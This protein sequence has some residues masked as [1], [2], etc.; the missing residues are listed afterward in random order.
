[1]PHAFTN[2][3]RPIWP[4]FFLWWFPNRSI[5]SRPSGVCER[6]S[7]WKCWIMR[8][9]SNCF[10][11]PPWTDRYKQNVF[12]LMAVVCN[13]V[14]IYI[15]YIIWFEASHQWVIDGD[16]KISKP[17]KSTYFWGWTSRNLIEAFGVNRRDVLR[18][19]LSLPARSSTRLASIV[20]V[21]NFEMGLSENDRKTMEHPH[22][23]LVHH[24][25]PHQSD[26]IVTLCRDCS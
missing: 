25:F 26:S 14:G 10:R 18:R 5:L 1:M 21:G 9:W 23:L 4:C 12:Q 11:R 6:S 7:C 13:G 20:G 3:I 19:F 22:D 24:H 17:L 8:T 15:Q 16:Q 2:A